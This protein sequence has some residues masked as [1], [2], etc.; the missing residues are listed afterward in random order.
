VYE[1]GRGEIWGGFQDEDQD[2]CSAGITASLYSR[3]AAGGRGGDVYYLSVCGKD[4]LTR[5]ALADVV[6]HG[7]PVSQV[8]EWLY[9]ALQARVSQNAGSEVLQELNELAVE[10]GIRSMATAALTSFL[11]TDS[12]AY[13]SYAG[14]APTLVYRADQ[15]RWCPADFDPSESR[16]PNAPLGVVP[17]ARYDERQEPLR[18]GDRLFA[19]TDGLVEGR[20]ATGATFGEARLRAIL[21]DQAQAPLQA[22]KKTVLEE[23][24]GHTGGSLVHDDV[25]LVAIEV[26]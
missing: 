3:A 5:L 21:E 16:Y 1:M 4:R 8:S 9:Q 25:T 13:F 14:H 17:G 19:Y 7:A 12:N 6:G 26:R 15:R 24:R 22:L 20:D 10:R 23:V 18:S 2:L 11:V